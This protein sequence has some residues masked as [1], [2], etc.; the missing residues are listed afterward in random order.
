MIVTIK[1]T[2]LTHSLGV[3]HLVLVRALGSQAASTIQVVAMVAHTFCIVL[4][5]SVR[6]PS[7][8]LFGPRFP[9]H[10]IRGLCLNHS[11][12]LMWHRQTSIVSLD[13][14]DLEYW[15]DC[16]GLLLKVQVF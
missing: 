2:V 16:F 4:H 9:L 7:H 15:L 13:L 6:A 11:I 14:L 1:V 12:T 3:Y 8:C 10:L 5:L